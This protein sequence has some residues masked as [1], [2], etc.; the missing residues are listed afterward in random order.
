MGGRGKQEYPPGIRIDDQATSGTRPLRRTG[1]ASK[2]EDSS[3]SLEH[4]RADH[5]TRDGKCGTADDRFGSRIQSPG[6]GR[7]ISSDESARQND[8]PGTRPC[9]RHISQ[10]RK[11]VVRPCVGTKRTGARNLHR[12]DRG[13]ALLVSAHHEDEVEKVLSVASAQGG[14]SGASSAGSEAG[15]V[16]PLIRRRVVDRDLIVQHGEDMAIRESGH[17]DAVQGPRRIAEGGRGLESAIGPAGFADLRG[18][19]HDPLVRKL[20][21]PTADDQD[22]FFIE[23]DGGCFGP[24]FQEGISNGEP[25]EPWIVDL[26]PGGRLQAFGETT[27][28]DRRLPG[29]HRGGS[30][31]RDPRRG[32]SRPPAG[33]DR[34]IVQG[35]DHRDGGKGSE[36]FS[37]REVHQSSYRTVALRT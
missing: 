22:P 26:N 27:D 4:P 24:G 33:T 20:P 30:G 13:L 2:Q 35:R 17:R 16:R 29:P 19:A 8:G 1:L 7:G 28:E 10:E 3:A 31:D 36:E 32:S 12:F 21:R 5:T 9:E 25:A 15:L 23:G 37:S 14:H 34:R 6:F 11:V 18:P